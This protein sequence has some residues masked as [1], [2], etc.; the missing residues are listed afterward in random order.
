MA[1]FFELLRNRR[2]CRKFKDQPVEQD[3]IETLKRCA[4]M[5][6]AGKRSNEWD[7]Y[8]VT[9]KDKLNALSTAKANG[10]ALL[11]DAPLAIVVTLDASKADTF[12]EDGSIA[13]IILQLAAAD[14]DLGSCWVQMRLRQDVNGISAEQ[15]V[16]DILNLPADTTVL[17]AVAIGY[18]DD[19]RKPYDI[20]KLPYEKWHVL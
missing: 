15:R 10:A 11:A 19:E 3:K 16:K 20:D 13:A 7:F 9:D 17:C 5:S 6:P 2:S 8:V 1:S 4:L 12:V 18:K 14:L